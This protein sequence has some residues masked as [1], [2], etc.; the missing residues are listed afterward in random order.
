MKAICDKGCD[1]E[2]EV[3]KISTRPLPVGKERRYFSCP[4]C[5]KEY[6]CGVFDVKPKNCNI[7]GLKVL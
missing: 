5:F 4:H 3:D 7:N 1:K 2:F 6:S